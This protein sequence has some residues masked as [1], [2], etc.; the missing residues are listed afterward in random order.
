M[1]GNHC[2]LGRE[3]PGIFYL[4][5]FDEFDNP[6]EF[7]EIPSDIACSISTPQGDEVMISTT[8]LKD[9]L[10]IT[11]DKLNLEI[12]VYNSDLIPDGQSLHFRSRPRLSG[13]LKI[14]NHVF[15]SVHEA[16]LVN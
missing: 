9:S 4:S 7:A 14:R 16:N 3:R 2:R 15:Q 6:M 10:K 11:N 5:R 8:I 1:P 12:P 13:M